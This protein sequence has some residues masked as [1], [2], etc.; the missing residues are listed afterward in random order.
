LARRGNNR[1]FLWVPRFIDNV[2][3]SRVSDTNLRKY[4]IGMSRGTLKAGLA[5]PAKPAKRENHST[6]KGN[7]YTNTLHSHPSK[8]TPDPPPAPKLPPHL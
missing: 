2:T 4:T 6:P 8:G 7:K 5:K 3:A 1:K